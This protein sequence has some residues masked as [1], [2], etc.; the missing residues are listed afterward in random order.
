VD[1]LA[2]G[3]YLLCFLLTVGMPAQAFQI[4]FLSSVFPFLLNTLERSRKRSLFLSLVHSSQLPQVQVTA[5]LGCSSVAW[6]KY[7]RKQLGGENYMGFWS[8]RV[9]SGVQL[10]AFI[11]LGTTVWKICVWTEGSAVKST[12][13]S[14]RESQLGRQQ[15][16]QVAYDWFPCLYSLLALHSH[17][18]HTHL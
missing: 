15:P 11:A 14:S 12:C 5:V 2:F 7:L 13:C 4:S 6:I 16:H 10:T 9:G 8:W 18:K 3:R 1:I 17:A